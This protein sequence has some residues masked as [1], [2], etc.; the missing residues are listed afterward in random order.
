MSDREQLRAIVDD[1]VSVL[2]TQ[3]RAMERLVAHIEQV[4]GH[5]GGT[6][7]LSVIASELSGI[8][9]RIRQLARVKRRE[10]EVDLRILDRLCFRVAHP[11]HKLGIERFEGNRIVNSISIKKP[12]LSCCLEP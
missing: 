11:R 9:R 4:A 8:H 5:V 12:P 2:H 7:E 3:A 10:H 6:G 1:L